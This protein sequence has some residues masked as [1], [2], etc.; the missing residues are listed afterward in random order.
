M[1]IQVGMIFKCINSNGLYTQS[2]E[3]YQVGA[4][5]GSEVYLKGLKG[6][7]TVM[8]R[9]LQK[10]FVFISET[11]PKNFGMTPEK[12]KKYQELGAQYPTLKGFIYNSLLNDQEDKIY[13]L[14]DHCDTEII[15]Q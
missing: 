9:D 8:M 4:V 3:V 1:N 11:A 10:K 14:L 6:G 7:T 5:Q 13:E 2:G 15:T 12:L